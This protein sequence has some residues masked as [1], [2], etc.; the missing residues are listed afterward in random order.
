L[1]D[2]SM[3]HHGLDNFMSMTLLDIGIGMTILWLSWPSWSWSLSLVLTTQVWLTLCIVI[4]KCAHE[5]GATNHMRPWTRCHESYARCDGFW[6]GEGYDAIISTSYV[7]HPSIF[8]WWSEHDRRSQGA[9]P[10]RSTFGK[11]TW[12]GRRCGT[13]VKLAHHMKIG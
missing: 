4:A 10:R 12:R 9:N 6:S 5:L 3:L 7:H 8:E 13:Q 1:L 2:I 11:L